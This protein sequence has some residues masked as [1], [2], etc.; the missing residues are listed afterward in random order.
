[1]T[2]HP[3]I[4][5]SENENAYG[6]VYLRRETE[7]SMLFELIK[8]RAVERTTEIRDLIIRLQEIVPP[9]IRKKVAA[10]ADHDL[11]QGWFDASQT[12]TVHSFDD[13]CS[14]AFTGLG[15][16]GRVLLALRLV[17][18]WNQVTF[19]TTTELMEGPAEPPQDVPSRSVDAAKLAPPDLKLVPDN[20][21]GPSAA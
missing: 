19:I 6:N 13:W 21:D 12:G 8:A 20:D 10:L 2:T 3:T 11:A 5:E 16:V 1:M 7:Q 18:F 17:W 15:S 9:D 4:D 14:H